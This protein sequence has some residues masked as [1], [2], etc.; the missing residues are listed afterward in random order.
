MSRLYF[1]HYF[2]DSVCVICFLCIKFGKFA[3]NNRYILGNNLKFERIMGLKNG[4]EGI[5]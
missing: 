4:N 3:K 5:E 1:L 2:E